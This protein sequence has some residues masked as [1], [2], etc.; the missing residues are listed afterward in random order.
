MAVVISDT[1]PLRALAHL[2]HLE[3]LEDLFGR[4][5]L[6]PA[7][8]REASYP[9]GDL[10]AVDVAAWRF[11]EIRVP[12]NP[13]RVAEL[14]SELDPGEAEAIALAEEWRAELVLMDERTGREV[15]CQCGFT[16]LGTL[17]ILMRAKERRLC[18]AIAS[19]VDR[20]RSELNFFISTELRQ[21]ILHQ[22]G[23]DA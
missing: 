8:A 20:L 15:A 12:Q 21:C 23:E 14:R 3:W 4:V 11:L 6:P 17:G 13:Q 1:S 5:L 16:V 2:G 7:V 10:V 18:P 19:L 22:A 9:P